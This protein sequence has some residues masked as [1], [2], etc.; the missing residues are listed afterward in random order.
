MG[1][2]GV[3]AHSYGER[4]GERCDLSP[5]PCHTSECDAVR[6]PDE[7]TAA[8]E[9]DQ[10]TVAPDGSMDGYSRDEFPHWITIEGN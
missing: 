6:I 2:H 3:S 1:G 4:F 9:L 7:Q 10:L 8:G 5:P